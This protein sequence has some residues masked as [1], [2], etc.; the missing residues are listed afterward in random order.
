MVFTCGYL[1]VCML[2]IKLAIT[3]LELLYITRTIRNYFYLF[4]N[5]VRTVSLNAS[6]VEMFVVKS[7]FRFSVGSNLN[8]V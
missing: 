1:K 3:K 4:V 6:K 7:L 2:E 5:S 8:V